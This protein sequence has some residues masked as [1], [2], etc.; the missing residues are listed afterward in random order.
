MLW[1]VVLTALAQE[2]VPAEEPPPVESI[3]VKLDVTLEKADEQLEA[4]DELVRQLKAAAE[5]KKAEEAKKEEEL[6]DSVDTGG[7]PIE[8]AVTEVPA[9]TGPPKLPAPTVLKPAPTID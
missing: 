1:I 7:L 4:I 6:V 5:A 8:P 3:A 2:S 9:D